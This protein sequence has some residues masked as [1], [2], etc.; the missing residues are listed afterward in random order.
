MKYFNNPKTEEELK[1]QYR[2]LLI[3]YD[4]RSEKNATVIAEIKKE[5]DT[6]LMQI[7]R[8][9]GYRTMSEKIIDGAKDI[10]TGI[11]E[12]RREEERRVNNL[13]NHNYSKAEIQNLI[14]ETTKCIHKIVRSI[15]KKQSLDYI[16]L[17]N[18][19]KSCDTEQI[20]RWFNTHMEHMVIPALSREYNETREKLEYALKSQSNDKKSQEAYMIQMEKMMGKQIITAFDK[21]E[22]ELVDPI[23]VAEQSVI[24]QERKKSDKKFDKFIK[25]AFIGGWLISCIYMIFEVLTNKYTDVGE[26]LFFIVASAIGFYLMYFLLII[27]P[28]KVEVAF[29]KKTFAGIGNRKHNSRV[30]EKKKYQSDV[31]KNSLLRIIVRFLGF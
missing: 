25:M 19:V 31:A 1:D 11:V 15:L 9:N 10:H 18:V 6:I 14:L 12:T 20:A 13:K 5:H 30:S 23:I 27:I 8:A 28:K 4:Y 26:G 3:K 17:R 7:K 21:Y 16:S 22:A 2:K 24:K 29:N